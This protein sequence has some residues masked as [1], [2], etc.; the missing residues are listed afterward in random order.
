MNKSKNSITSFNK[1]ILKLVVAAL[2]VLSVGVFTSQKAN[3]EV[4]AMTVRLSPSATGGRSAISNLMDAVPSFGGDV[5]WKSGQYRTMKLNRGSTVTITGKYYYKLFLGRL[6]L[7]T[8]AKYNVKVPT[9]SYN[10]EI[11]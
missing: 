1:N 9:N 4:K 3:A 5:G 10:L 8:L 2:V 7:G 11:K 6:Q